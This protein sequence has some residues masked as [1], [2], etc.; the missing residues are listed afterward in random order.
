LLKLLERALV[1]R[2]AGI[3]AV[4]DSIADW[5]AREYRIA[6]PAVVRN[7]PDVPPGAD[8]S[9][10]GLLRSTL[11]IPDGHLM[12]LYVGGLFRFRRIRAVSEVFSRCPKT[13][14]PCCGLRRSRGEVRAAAAA[15]STF[16]ST[17]RY[18]LEVS[19]LTSGADVGLVEWRTFA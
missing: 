12:F 16:T 3:V 6:R 2:C 17:R 14:T 18:L 9:Q 1:G 11:G 15:R 4:N 8:T 5:Y 7:I 19:V 10:S 13:V